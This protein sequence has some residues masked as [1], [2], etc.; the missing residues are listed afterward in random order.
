LECFNC[1]KKGHI[2]TKCWAKGGGKE[3]QGL[4]K[5]AGVRDGAAAAAEQEQDV[6]AWAVIEEA[7]ESTVEVLCSPVM[8][9]EESPD[10]ITVETKLYDLGASRHMSPFR[11]K[12]VTYQPIPVAI[13]PQRVTLPER[14]VPRCYV[15]S[16]P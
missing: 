12:F 3:G 10:I 15:F 8:V 16:C 2:K 13:F 14:K 5:K 1:H 11:N 9:A 6:E 4:K 7:E